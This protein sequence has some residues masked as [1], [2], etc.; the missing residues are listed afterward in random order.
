[1]EKHN[2]DKYLQT[3]RS[4]IVTTIHNNLGA[5]KSP[6]SSASNGLTSEGLRS[7][8]TPIAE[9]D[10]T[11]DN[12]PTKEPSLIANGYGIDP[13]ATVVPH[14][15]PTGDPLKSPDNESVVSDSQVHPCINTLVYFCILLYIIVFYIDTQFISEPVNIRYRYDVF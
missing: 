11:F 9:Q 4:S 7:A 8:L 15:L 14:A 2:A 13:M 1:M 5:S 3:Q 12:E 6:S 10:F